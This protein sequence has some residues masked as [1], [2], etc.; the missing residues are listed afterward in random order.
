MLQKIM[1]V[2]KETIL[3][4]KPGMKPLYSEAPQ[5]KKPAQGKRGKP[6]AKNAGRPKS[7]NYARIVTRN[8]HVFSQ[9]SA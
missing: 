5:R 1:M 9:A 6:Y 8:D 4:A 3:P 7:R 2:T